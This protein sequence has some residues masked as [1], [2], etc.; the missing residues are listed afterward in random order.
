VKTITRS[1]SRVSLGQVFECNV[2]KCA[3]HQA[4]KLILLCKLTFDERSVVH[5]VDG[6]RLQNL[7]DQTGLRSQVYRFGLGLCKLMKGS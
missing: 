1:T 4:L 7:A 2:T 6:G 3:P 5:R